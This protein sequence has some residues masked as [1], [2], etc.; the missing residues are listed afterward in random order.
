[1]SSLS[2]WVSDL[3]REV[4]LVVAGEGDQLAESGHAAG[5]PTQSHSAIRLHR[6]SI[7]ISHHG[8]HRK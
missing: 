4:H 3:V 7:A 6:R 1:M 2:P 8:P 5:R